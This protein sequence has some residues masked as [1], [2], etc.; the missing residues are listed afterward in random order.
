MELQ[1]VW[2]V[3]V[4]GDLVVIPTFS[5]ATAGYFL[6]T[7]PVAVSSVRARDEF[8]RTLDAT[9][10]TGNPRVPTPTRNC[11]PKPVVLRYA[12]VRSWKA[13][14]SKAVCFTI[15]HFEGALELSVTGRGDDGRWTDSPIEAVGFSDSAGSAGTV[16]RIISRVSHEPNRT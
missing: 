14:E 11:F 2:H 12:G 10:T 7:E 3:Y 6:D 5:R 9:I 15:Q 16:Q 1:A 4:R 8:V 13:L